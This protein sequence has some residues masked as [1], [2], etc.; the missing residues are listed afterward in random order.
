[1][2]V[3]SVFFF[4]F[5]FSLTKVYYFISQHYS[6]HILSL[7]TKKILNFRLTSSFFTHF[8]LFINQFSLCVYIF[9]LI[10]KPH[11]NLIGP[12]KREHNF[13]IYF[14]LFFHLFF[15]KKSSFLSTFSP[16]I[17]SKNCF[18][19]LFFTIFYAILYFFSSKKHL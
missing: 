2:R 19:H 9:F 12:D 4:L 8:Y 16:K 1:M 11:Q 14:L 17:D 18:F 15:T 7:L 10:K 6:V 5:S 13:F 3:C